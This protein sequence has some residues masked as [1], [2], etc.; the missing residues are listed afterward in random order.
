[1]LL[2]LAHEGSVVQVA[3]APGTIILLGA[4]IISP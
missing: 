2:L 3:P 4:T 1:V